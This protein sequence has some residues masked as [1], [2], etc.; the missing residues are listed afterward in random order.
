PRP[1]KNAC[2]R[3][4]RGTNVAHRPGSV[5]QIQAAVSAPSPIAQSRWQAVIERL[6]D[7]STVLVVIVLLIIFGLTSKNFLRIDNLLNIVKQMSIVGI[8][9]IGM[10]MVILIGGIDLSVGSVALI[11]GGVTATL[12]AKADT[13]WPASLAIMVGLLVGGT[14]G[15]VNGLL[16]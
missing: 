7:Y 6:P 15:L 12:M 10:T 13:P 3:P 4:S 5:E 9:A 16:I 1:A 2:F 14:V 11:S 8:L